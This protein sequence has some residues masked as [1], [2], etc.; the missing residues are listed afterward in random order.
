MRFCFGA[1]YDKVWARARSCHC[2][3]FA[4]C[5]CVSGNGE[6]E[7]GRDGFLGL[8]L[9]FYFFFFERVGI[10][11]RVGFMGLSGNVRLSEYCGIDADV[12][13]FFNLVKI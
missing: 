11:Y 2:V 10:S 9:G 7:I 12:V 3:G 13:T 8:R 6:E 4:Y 1:T 5:S